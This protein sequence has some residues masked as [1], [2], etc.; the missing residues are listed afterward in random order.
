MSSKI[1]SYET[2][3][4]ALSGVCVS[5]GS[6]LSTQ[7]AIYSILKSALLYSILCLCSQSKFCHTLKKSRALTGQFLDCFQSVFKVSSWKYLIFKNAKSAVCLLILPTYIFK[8]IIIISGKL[9][10]HDTCYTI[11][12]SENSHDF[13]R[14]QKI[15]KDH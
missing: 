6:K 1:F 3:V 4:H 10:C 9:R 15:K 2:L 8:I 12:H 7:S 5:Q 11:R 14:N 13:R